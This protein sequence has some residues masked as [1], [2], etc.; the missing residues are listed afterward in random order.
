M[1]RGHQQLNRELTRANAPC[2]ARSDN[3]AT[4]HSLRPR[5]GTR[6]SILL[7]AVLVASILL[8]GWTTVGHAAGGSAGFVS[9]PY[10]PFQLAF[11]PPG[12]QVFTKP[13]P[14]YGLRLALLHGTQKKVIGLDAGLFVDVVDLT[15][16]Q[17]GLGNQVFGKMRGVQI[18][19]AN[20]NDS[21]AG[22]Q[23]GIVNRTHKMRGIQIG[24]INWNDG[25]LVPFLPFF[26]FHF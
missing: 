19:V 7:R 26:N 10:T 9:A 16:L 12:L 24:L 5:L 21:G 4:P 23:I 8:T 2:G 18:G 1:N 17:T 3:R 11:G 15:G 20:S 25:A 13:T 14:V 22:V 6:G